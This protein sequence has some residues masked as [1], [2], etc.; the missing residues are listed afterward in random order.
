MNTFKAFTKQLALQADRA[1]LGAQE[2]D[3]LRLDLTA[4]E[5]AT[6]DVSVKKTRKNF[7]KDF[8]G[9]KRFLLTSSA[10]FLVLFTI[11]NAQAYGKI[12][13]A[14]V[15]ES[16]AEYEASLPVHTGN[17]LLA[18]PWTG[19]RLAQHVEAEKPLESIAYATDPL[20]AL[21]LKLS[22]PTSYDNRIVIPNLEIN[23][24][25][26]EPELGLEAVQNKNWEALEEQ[27]QG[28][29]LDGV[30]HYPGTAAP[31]QKGNAFLTGHSSNVFW[32][33]SIFNTVFALL[34]KIQVG[35]DIFVTYDQREYHYKVIEKKEVLPNDVSILK[36][37]PEKQLTL[38]TC[39]PVGTTLKRLVVTAELQEE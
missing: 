25:V 1:I 22:A 23:A 17:Q 9:M 10:F 14:S 11:T 31:G 16:M 15:K 12:A 28:S 34:P 4:H 32:E 21:G 29:L 2:A 7:R 33:K 18:D 6:W 35:D 30:V 8:F 19:E 39:T 24:P 27:I 20:F 37:G 13:L 5:K 38:V 26:V 3:H 36:Q